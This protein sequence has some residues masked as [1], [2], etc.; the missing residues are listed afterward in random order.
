MSL[1]CYKFLA[2]SL[3]DL[4]DTQIVNTQ[5]IQA[6]SSPQLRNC[7]TNHQGD[8]TKYQK[9]FKFAKIWMVK[10]GLLSYNFG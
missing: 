7:M 8:R 3:V 5:V 6:F 2:C 1:S 10:S 9:F 4:H